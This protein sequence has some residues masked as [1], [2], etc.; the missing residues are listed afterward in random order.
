MHEMSIAESIIGIV[1]EELARH[2]RHAAGSG[3]PHVRTIDLKIGRLRAV[4]PDNL[5][6]CFA[7]ASRGTVLEGA[8]LE[9]EEVPVR[10]SCGRCRQISI[11]EEPLFRCGRCGD[12]DLEVISGMELEIDSIEVDDEQDEVFT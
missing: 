8:V 9:I 10:V 4:V 12:T 3:R 2:C 1:D 7:A 6:F 11:L 5:E